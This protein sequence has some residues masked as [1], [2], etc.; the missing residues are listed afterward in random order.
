MTRG[1]NGCYSRSPPDLGLGWCL[2]SLSWMRVGRG[3][4]C[5]ARGR[6]VAC[7]GR[8]SRRTPPLGPPMRARGVGSR[9]HLLQPREW[10]FPERDLSRREM[11]TIILKACGGNVRWLG[12]E[13]CV[14]HDQLRGEPRVHRRSPRGSQRIPASG[15]RHQAA[16]LQLL[17]AY[18]RGSRICIFPPATSCPS[19]ILQIPPSSSLTQTGHIGVGCSDTT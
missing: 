2:W 15:S 12:S 14:T 7:R 1:L 9:I 18:L 16:G 4:R 13:L 17:P 5:S 10:A 11:A 8:G 3:G 19:R 6:A